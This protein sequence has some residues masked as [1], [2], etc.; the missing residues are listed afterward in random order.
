MAS[1]LLP[2][3]LP[4]LCLS[5]LLLALALGAHPARA[6]VV[7]GHIRTTEPTAFLAKFCYVHTGTMHDAPVP[8]AAAFAPFRAVFRAFSCGYVKR[9]G[10]GRHVSFLDDVQR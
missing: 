9:A 6:E 3:P 8:R 2:L 7:S 5:L 1:L 10:V 4:L